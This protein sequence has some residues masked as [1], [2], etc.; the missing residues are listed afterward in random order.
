MSSLPHFSSYA[1]NNIN[2]RSRIPGL[3][4]L[5]LSKYCWRD[6]SLPLS[7]R[8]NF[9]IKSAI[10]SKRESF[11]PFFAAW[12]SLPSKKVQYLVSLLTFLC[13][14]G[15]QRV[16]SVN[17]NPCRRNTYPLKKIFWSVFIFLNSL[18]LRF[19]KSLY[20]APWCNGYQYYTT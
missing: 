16:G 9:Q 17:E 4:R 19:R 2:Q 13:Y 6:P 10:I 14:L 18:R 7:M 11:F 15:D 12:Y 8:I 3:P 1:E 20:L 5:R